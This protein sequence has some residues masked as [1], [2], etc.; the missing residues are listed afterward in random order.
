MRKIVFPALAAA[1]VLMAG[2]VGCTNRDSE[3]TKA[4]APATA[5][6]ASTE[7]KT[8][9]KTEVKVEEVFSGSKT[10]NGTALSYP[11]GN[12]ELRLYRVEI[13]VGGKIPM[14]THPAPMLVHVQ[15]FESGD[16]LNTR[17]QAD[18]TEVSSVFK[19]GESFIE[20]SSEPHFVQNN[21]DKPT[22]V[23]VMVASVEGMPTTEWGQ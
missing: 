8:E 14:H 11:E 10:L 5:E 20:G 4:A 9:D 23:W 1:S 22:I 16:L 21:S 2:V 15:D 19:P 17:V 18:G 3:T 12:P 7:V 6:A 13:P